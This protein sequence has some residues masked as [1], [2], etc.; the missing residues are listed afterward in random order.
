MTS[1]LSSATS[2]VDFT[3]IAERSDG[4]RFT[5]N[6]GASTP[7]TSYESASTSKMVTAAV[8]LRLVQDGYLNLTDKPHDRITG[9][10][11]GSGDSLYN[12]TLAHLLSFRSGLEDEPACLNFGASDF[13]TCAKNAGT[14]NAGN[15][16][17][18][19]QEFYYSGSHMQVA[20]LMAAKARNKTWAQIFSDFKTLTGLFASSTYDLPSSTNP[21]LGGGMHWTANDYMAFLK[22]L[23]NGQI[24]NSTY[25]NQMLTDQ[26]ASAT[27]T[28]SPVSAIGE[29]WHYGFGLWHE[30]Q[31]AT[32]NCTPGTRVSSPGA[33]GAYPFW[34]RTNNYF[35]I[36]ARQGSL[37]TYPNGIAI[38]RTVRAKAEAWASCL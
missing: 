35:G 15:G 8:I 33:Y 16:V 38:E 14:T 7:T 12:M 22:A 21:R 26:T 10:T 25:L 4:R 20:G 30:C 24:L 13:E 28:Y 32:Y 9:W 34:D 5:Y 1:L 18:P 29:A 11:I 3:Y 17:V 2:E 6:R 23:K 19:G 27:F 36:V 31:S 37:G